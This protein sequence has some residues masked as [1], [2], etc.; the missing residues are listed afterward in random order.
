MRLNM[1]VHEVSLNID[2]DIVVPEVDPDLFPGLLERPQPDA[3]QFRLP[4]VE[5]KIA[6][7]LAKQPVDQSLVLF[8]VEPTLTQ[9]HIDKE[10]SVKH[11]QPCAQHYSCQHDHPY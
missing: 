6:V 8:F 7:L 11:P 2:E 5:V 1:S 10:H 3:K 4:E 9:W